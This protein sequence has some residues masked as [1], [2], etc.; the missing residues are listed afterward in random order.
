MIYVVTGTTESGD[1]IPVLAFSYMPS[2]EE[3]DNLYRKIMPEEYII[4]DGEEVSLI[5]WDVLQTEVINE[6]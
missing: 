1:N 4:E 3:I 5:Y 6:D 2:G